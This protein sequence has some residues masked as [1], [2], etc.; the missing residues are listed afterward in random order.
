[1]TRE[2]AN[3]KRDER[4]YKREQHIQKQEPES[5]VARLWREFLLEIALYP[6]DKESLKGFS[7]EMLGPDLHCRVVT[8]AVVNG[9]TAGYTAFDSEVWPFWG[10]P[11]Q[12]HDIE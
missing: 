11:I 10:P 4:Y 8:P 9:W 7:R 1:M 6:D 12:L 5:A 3:C 2:L